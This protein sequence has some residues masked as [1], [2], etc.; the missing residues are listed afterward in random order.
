MTI[1]LKL[2]QKEIAHL[3]VTYQADSYV[4]SNPHIQFLAK[5]QG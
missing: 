3:I 4:T 1:V 2:A 5:P